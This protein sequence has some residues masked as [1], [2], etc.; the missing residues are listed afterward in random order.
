M[1]RKLIV[2]D[3]LNPEIYRCISSDFINR[4]VVITEK[5]IDHVKEGH[6]ESFDYVMGCLKDTLE[7][8][9]YIIRDVHPNTGLVIKKFSEGEKAVQIILKLTVDYNKPE[10]KH[11]IISVWAISQRRL[12]SYLRNKDILYKRY[13]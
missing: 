2:I 8:P 12:E 5:R 1:S 4:E 9:D 3:E 11:S 6:P 7:N 10:Y 13:D